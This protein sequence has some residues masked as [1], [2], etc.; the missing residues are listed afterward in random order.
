MASVI[1]T[2]IPEQQFELV[3][4]RIGEILFEELANQV[5]LG[6]TDADVKI[7]TERIVP[8]NQ[9]ETTSLNLIFSNG[10]YPM[11]TAVYADGVYTFF[12][13]CY[14]TSPTVGTNRG[15]K[16]SLSGL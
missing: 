10:D 5:M 13:D 4:N 11:Q 7:Y 3:R 8:M 9:G 15:D 6:N 16:L 14:N 2:V 12:I 1:N